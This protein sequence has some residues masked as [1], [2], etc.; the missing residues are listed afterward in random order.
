MWSSTLNTLTGIHEKPTVNTTPKGEKTERSPW[1]Q[2]GT[3][4]A[5]VLSDTVL[6]FEPEQL[7][8]ERGEK[9]YGPERQ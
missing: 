7:L 3:G 8:N 4:Q 6:K 9:A 2:D 1:D 5:P